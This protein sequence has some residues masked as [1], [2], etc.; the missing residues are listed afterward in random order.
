MEPRGRE[1]DDINNT[2]EVQ[3]LLSFPRECIFLKKVFECKFLFK[4]KFAVRI[5]RATIEATILPISQNKSTTTTRTR[6]VFH[7]LIV[8]YGRNLVGWLFFLSILTKWELS[9]ES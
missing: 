4:N 8:F 1:K 2:R 3:C 7:S 9:D 6:F 5:V